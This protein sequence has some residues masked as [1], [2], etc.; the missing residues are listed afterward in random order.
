MLE[1][2]GQMAGQALSLIL[3]E[4]GAPLVAGG[5]VVLDMFSTSAGPDNEWCHDAFDLWTAAYE[6]E[7]AYFRAQR[8]ASEH[9]RTI[10]G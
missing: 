2:C 8:K 9:A 6:P 1:A 10:V 7:A 3:A 5:E 4:E